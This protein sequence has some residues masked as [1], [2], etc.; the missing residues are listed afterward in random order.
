[1]SE[2]CTFQNLTPTY[3]AGSQ[4]PRNVKLTFIYEFDSKEGSSYSTIYCFII[5]NPVYV[6][7]RGIKYSTF[8]QSASVLQC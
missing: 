7:G 6:G 2:I 8:A 4:G 1:M 3:Q 5:I